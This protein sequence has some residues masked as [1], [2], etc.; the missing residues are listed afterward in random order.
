MAVRTAEAAVRLILD[1]DATS[2]Q[3]LAFINSAS[4]W[5]DTHL[6]GACSKLSTALLTE[7]ETYLSA[8]F[9]T[10]R[11][12]RLTSGRLDDVQEAYQRDKT[13][14]EYLSTA[15]ALDPC[16]IL[17]EEFLDQGKRAKVRF[18]V[19][20]GFDSTLDLPSDPA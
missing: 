19:G 13:I 20:A 12:P 16:G 6:E 11:D 4:L 18:R 8:Y 7:I 14:S 9:V 17:E 1:T 3:V 5:I 10:L 2:P 15:I